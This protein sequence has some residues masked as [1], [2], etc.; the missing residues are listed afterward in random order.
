M[1]AASDYPLWSPRER[2][3]VRGAPR[4]SDLRSHE[5]VRV[6]Q[7]TTRTVSDGGG[8]SRADPSLS[9]SLLPFWNESPTPPS[10]RVASIPR[11]LPDGGSWH[12]G[13][14]FMASRCSSWIDRWV[15][16]QVSGAV[17]SAQTPLNGHAR[18]ARKA[19]GK[20]HTARGR[21]KLVISLACAFPAAFPFRAAS[22]A[23]C[24][25]ALRVC[26][27]HGK[28]RKAMTRLTA[29]RLCMHEHREGCKLGEFAAWRPC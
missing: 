11:I 7:G 29:S 17:E 12:T 4:E 20:P 13:A 25:V 3:G 23:G 2:D 19:V 27:P 1:R 21:S 24:E 26:F 22:D 9:A 10:G 6:G 16:G 8:S 28:N 5:N 18:C 15:E 14:L